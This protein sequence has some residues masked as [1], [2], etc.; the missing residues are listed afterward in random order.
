MRET[1][2]IVA[3][4]WRGETI[5]VEADS[6]PVS[7]RAPRLPA[8]LEPVADRSASIDF[9]R[10][11]ELIRTCSGALA[12]ALESIPEP[13]SATVEFGMKFAAEAGLPVLTKVSTD[14]TIKVSITWKS[15]PPAK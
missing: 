5:L 13:E 2:V 8:G 15:K 14:A 3:M 9:A 12:E 6:A 4:T 11:T 10:V 7:M 1:D